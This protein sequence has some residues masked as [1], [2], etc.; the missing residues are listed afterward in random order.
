VAQI[1]QK[2]P[3]S[4]RQSG[5]VGT[6]LYECPRGT[7]VLRCPHGSVSW[8][9]VRPLIRL[10]LVHHALPSCTR[11]PGSALLCATCSLPHVGR[12]PRFRRARF[13]HADVKEDTPHKAVIRLDDVPLLT[14]AWRDAAPG[15]F[16]LSFSFSF[17][18]ADC[19]PFSHM[20][21]TP[22]ATRRIASRRPCCAAPCCSC[23]AAPC[24]PCCVTPR[25]F[26]TCR[27]APRRPCCSRPPCFSPSAFL[28]DS[29]P[30]PPS[31]RSG[32]HSFPPSGPGA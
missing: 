9:A 23:C 5:F 19:F 24:R 4:P 1:S 25:P 17:S 32:T 22:F 7:D 29:T 15:V 14:N 2:S 18:F 26:A 30:P 3:W 11:S 16:F 27:V 31:P 21:P 8:F 13:F 28:C 12:Q 10:L 20:Y 6:T